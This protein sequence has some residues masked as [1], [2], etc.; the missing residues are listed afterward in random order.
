MPSCPTCGSELVSAG[1]GPVCVNCQQAARNP[2]A[3]RTAEPSAIEIPRITVTHVL[4]ALNV[5][6]YLYMVL[7]GVPAVSPNGLQVL[8]F[9]ADNARYTLGGQL[10]RLLA[11]NYIHFGILHLAVNMWC[12]WGLGRLAEAFYRPKDYILLYTFT[13]LCSSLLTVVW[14]PYGV[15]AGA[16]GAIFG[17]A[18]LMLATL[19]WGKLPISK[20]AKEQIF[21]GVLQFAA[22]NLFIGALQPHVDNAG[23]I[24]G[25]LGGIIVGIVLGKRL[26][27][28]ESSRRYRRRAWLVLWMGLFLAIGYA[29]WLWNGVS[30]K[31]QRQSVPTRSSV[32]SGV[33]HA[34]L[35][36]PSEVDSGS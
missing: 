28:S 26:D 30:I 1:V 7:R 8:P 32:D 27:D 6:F 10:W 2:V 24:G 33:V 23:H 20:E 19:Q 18:G 13:G 3:V 16:S 35:C 34:A 12:L 17:L 9:G 15:S 29:F 5:L 11:S 25:L 36:C 21:K 14:K 31:F 22:L 4:I